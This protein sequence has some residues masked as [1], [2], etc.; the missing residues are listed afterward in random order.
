MPSFV[1]GMSAADNIKPQTPDTQNN[2][3]NKTEEQNRRTK[4]QCKGGEKD[5]KGLKLVP[6]CP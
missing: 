2:S 1:N 4:Q 6:F 3:V 5:Q